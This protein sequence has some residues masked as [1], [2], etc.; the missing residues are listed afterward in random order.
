MDTADTNVLLGWVFEGATDALALVE[1]ILHCRPLERSCFCGHVLS[2]IGQQPC[3]RVACK[4]NLRHQSHV[5]AGIY[6]KRALPPCRSK[7]CS[8]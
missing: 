5:N 4:A 3:G 7:S 8:L 1:A 6:N 2:L